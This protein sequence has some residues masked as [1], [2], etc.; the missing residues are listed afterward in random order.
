MTPISDENTP[1]DIDQ[2]DPGYDELMRLVA[3][4]ESLQLKIQELRSEDGSSDSSI[5]SMVEQLEAE[6]QGLLQEINQYTCDTE[7]INKVVLEKDGFDSHRWWRAWKLLKTSVTK[8]ADF[9]QRRLHGEYITDEWG[10]DHEIL[11]TVKPALDYL[12]TNYWRV[13]TSGIE[14]IPGQGRALLVSN[15][16]GQLPFDGAMIAMAMLRAYPNNPA[17]RK[18]IRAQAK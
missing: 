9:V 10:Y 2:P 16:S 4:L 7:E 8:W 14:N 15:H 13:Q 1:L 5:G 3:E 6:L 18:A 17:A 11:E 12:Y